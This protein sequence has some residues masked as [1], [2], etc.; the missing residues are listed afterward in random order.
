GEDSGLHFIAKLD[1]TKY[2]KTL[3]KYDTQNMTNLY[4]TIIKKAFDKKLLIGG[5]ESFLIFCYAHID[6][7]QAKQI[8]DILCQVLQ[9]I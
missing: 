4:T 2:D 1:D 9:E 3:F 8:A 7:S 6:E 5:T